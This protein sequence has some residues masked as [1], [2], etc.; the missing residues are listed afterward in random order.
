MLCIDFKIFLCT[1][2]DCGH[3]VSRASVR[4]FPGTAVADS[5]Y[6]LHNELVAPNKSDKEANDAPELQLPPF[7]L[8]ERRYVGEVFVHG[9]KFPFQSSNDRRAPTARVTV[10]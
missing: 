3:I 6:L 8:H 5:A 2:E 9:C 4:H 7:R 10:A 1:G